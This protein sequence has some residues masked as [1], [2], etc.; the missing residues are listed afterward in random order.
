MKSVFGVLQNL[1]KFGPSQRGPLK[2]FS[3]LAIARHMAALPLTCLQFQHWKS[4]KY[5]YLRTA[6]SDAYKYAKFFQRTIP[7][8]NALPVELVE[9]ESPKAFQ[10]HC[11][12]SHSSNII[13]TCVHTARTVFLH[14]FL[15]EFT[16]TLL[17]NCMFRH[18]C[19]L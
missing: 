16:Y 13:T 10:F 5:E 15:F 2:N 7:V 19:S 14:L 6:S 9:A 17:P 12:C 1:Q 18:C 11:V 8:W 3:R 4:D